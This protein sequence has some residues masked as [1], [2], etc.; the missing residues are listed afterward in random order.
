MQVKLPCSRVQRQCP[1]PGIEPATFRN[2]R[3]FGYKRSS[4]PTVPH[5]FALFP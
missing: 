4:L 2:L 5:S 1:Y 3:P